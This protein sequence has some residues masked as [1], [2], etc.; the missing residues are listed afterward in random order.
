[1]AAVEISP[2]AEQ[3]I[4]N[5][6]TD[7]DNSIDNV[8]H[9]LQPPVPL[10]I[11]K[12][13]CDCIMN[14]NK[15]TETGTYEGDGNGVGHYR[16]FDGVSFMGNF[17]D[18]RMEGFGEYNW[19]ESTFYKGE[20]KNG[21]RHGS[22]EFFCKDIAS[23]YIGEWEEGL[24]H[25]FGKMTYDGQG[26]SYYEGNW[27]KGLKEGF[28]LMVYK[29]K[30]SYKGYWH[31]N[32][33]QGTGLMIWE[34][35]KESYDGEW[36]NGKPNG[37]GTHIW[38]IENSKHDIKPH[39]FPT[40]NAYRGGW[41]NGKRDGNSE[42][43]ILSGYGEFFYAS[44]AKYKGNWKDN[45]KNGFGVYLAEDGRRYEGYF[46][47]DRMT[48]EFLKF[49]NETPHYF[50]MDKLMCHYNQM[51][52]FS[53]LAESNSD[54]VMES[55]TTVNTELY[56]KNLEHLKSLNNVFLCYNS[57]LIE[58][59]KYYCEKRQKTNLSTN[60]MKNTFG[61]ISRIEVWD[62]LKVLTKHGLS[63]AS[64]IEI[65]RFWAMKFKN[66]NQYRKTRFDFPHDVNE[67]FNYQDFLDFLLTLSIFEKKEITK[68]FQNKIKKKE[69]ANLKNKNTSN[70][71]DS[72]KKN[73]F[74]A[75]FTVNINA[76]L[77]QQPPR[78]SVKS[79]NIVNSY[80]KGVHHSTSP[81]CNN[82]NAYNILKKQNF[83]LVLSDYLKSEIFWEEEKKLINFASSFENIK[84]ENFKNIGG[85]E[86]SNNED[87]NEQINAYERNLYQEF[88]RKFGERI[89]KLYFQRACKREHSL[90]GS[91]GD[92][93]MTLRDIIYMLDD[94]KLFDSDVT[95]LTI[96]KVLSFFSQDRERISD[97]SFYW[98]EYEMVPLTLFE[99]IFEFSKIK[100]NFKKLIW[101]K[102]LY[103]KLKKQKN[104]EFCLELE[105]KEK[106][107]T[108][109]TESANMEHITSDSPLTNA[110]VLENSKIDIDDK[111]AM[112]EPEQTKAIENI[113]VKAEENL[114]IKFENLSIDN[115]FVEN[116]KT[117]CK[118]DSPVKEENLNIET[119][120]EPFEECLLKMHDFFEN[121]LKKQ[122]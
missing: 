60:F 57:K 115:N 61:L 78:F 33:K 91:I 121:L 64:R 65:D 90:E 1:M 54:T 16:W 9:L 21:L 71:E 27:L 17:K 94:F 26:L 108:T 5:N 36:M 122:I 102:F 114:N 2:N 95:G 56:S 89:Y 79:N 25:G 101:D 85:N 32:L 48:D 97:G 44:G 75:N 40:N 69:N 58:I 24:P 98:V 103:D 76:A 4:S 22:G 87:V 119:L 23:G 29:S 84:D 63:D 11:N 19:P 82:G 46:E 80:S 68:K 42:E 43:N 77:Q 88:Q 51:D 117:E 93:T 31:Q 13:D 14:F 50:K 107:N 37:T 73:N 72:S 66:D 83:N 39:Q 35:L 96:N 7:V 49:L 86:Y 67:T 59:Y 81:N 55:N 15:L 38:Y 111:S 20:V 100:N 70:Y 8:Q 106:R 34:D 18:N 52:K 47:N 74:S 105:I 30:N 10:N 12:N 109:D 112:R 99:S 113:E 92:V 104:D 28:G 53:F 41:K 110:D 120:E 45:M 62:F 3:L 118:Q 116:S 6:S